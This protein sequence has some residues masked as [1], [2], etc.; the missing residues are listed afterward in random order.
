MADM[1]EVAD[2]LVGI[3]TAAIYPN[4][5][6]SAP[7]AGIGALG[8]KIYQG[9]PAPAALQVDG[10]RHIANISVWPSPQEKITTRRAAEWVQ[11]TAPAPTLTASV[12]GQAITLGGTVS[13]PQAAALIID[14]KDYAYGIQ[15]ADTLA[16]IAATLAAMVN[17]D[18]AATSA[19]AVITIPGAKRIVARIVAN[20]TS[21]KEVARESRVFIISIWAGCF[22]ERDPLARVLQPLLADL[23]RIT[24]PDGT[25]AISLYAGSSNVDSEQKQGIYRRDISL[26]IEYPTIVTRQDTTV[27][28]V[29]IRPAVEINGTSSPLPISNQ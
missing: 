3:I 23:T 4:G 21:A 25:V 12:A 19:G 11:I 15:A 5:V 14:G 26:A 6:N 2:A 20:G 17:A 27:Q 7:I 22:D 28:I 24:L 29:Q 10:Q 16:T 1:T 8:A 18:Q 9:W 13:R